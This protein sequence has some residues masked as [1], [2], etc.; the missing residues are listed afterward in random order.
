MAD[1]TPQGDTDTIS[2]PSEYL[3]VLS[4]I[5]NLQRMGIKLGLLNIRYLLKEMG[6]PE[7]N[8]GI[9]HIGG[10]NGKG[11]AAAMVTSILRE[12]GYTVG[13]FTSP[14]LLRY[15]ER[16][17][18]NGVDIVPEEV[19]EIFHKIKPI[20]DRMLAGEGGVDHPTFF[21]MTTAIALQHFAN[22]KVDYAVLEV[23]LGGRLDAT[24]APQ[25]KAVSAITSISRDHTQYLGTDL[26]TIAFEKAGIILPGVPVVLGVDM[27]NSPEAYDTIRKIA[28]ERGSPLVTVGPHEEDG[29][30]YELVSST[31]DGVTA[32]FTL[33]GT[34]LED[35]HIPLM[36]AYQAQNAAVA[37]GIIMTLNAQYGEDAGIS[38]EQIR[39]GLEK[40]KWPGRSELKELRGHQWLFDTAHNPEALGKVKENL[41]KNFSGKEKI[42]LFGVMGDKDYQEPLK[43]L[44]PLFKKVVLCKPKNPRVEE[45]EAVRQFIQDNDL[46]GEEDVFVVGSCGEAAEKALELAGEGDLIVNT[47]SIFCVSEVLGWLGE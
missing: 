5:Y 45:P 22:K 16:F 46:M 13:L 17:Q 34:T 10:T 41:E 15:E 32:N 26:G 36:G 20:L 14:H 35:V 23:G 37:L 39:A 3:D 8:Y 42:L 19:N 24:N 1:D 21:E 18:V 4:Y 47:G 30:R 25:M 6:N 31:T 9:I 43:E 7:N 2:G 33:A 28:E 40:T 11:S 44:L 38:N 29:I 12:R 27:E